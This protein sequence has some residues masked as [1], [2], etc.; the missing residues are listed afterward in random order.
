[1]FKHEFL[2]LW[3]L[4]SRKGTVE[5]NNKKVVQCDSLIIATIK[6]VKLRAMEN[7][8]AGW[9]IVVTVDATEKVKP[10]FAA[11]YYSVRVSALKP[12]LS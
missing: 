2:S 1:M 5:N 3:S 10:A 4:N 11:A 9:S 8:E 7:G 6:E 12:C